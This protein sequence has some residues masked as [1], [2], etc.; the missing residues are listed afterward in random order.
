[1]RSLLLVFLA[2][3]GAGMSVQA[4]VNARLRLAV[5]S[6]ALSALISFFVGGL[7]LAVLVAFRA[8]GPNRMS[9]LSAAPWWSW[10]GGIF[11]AAVV[12]A[13]VIGVPRVGT[14]GVVVAII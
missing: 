7:L 14:S 6:P 13:A 11:G 5:G 4:A 2:L 10:I 1:M 9:G 12:T 3:T 8:L